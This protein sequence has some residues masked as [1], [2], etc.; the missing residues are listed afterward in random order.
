MKRIFFVVALFISASLSAQEK[1]LKVVWDVS[2]SDTATTAAVFRQVNNA[3]AL[4]PDMEIEVVFHGSAIYG[5]MKDST[6]FT[7]RIKTAKEKGVVL[8]ACNNSLRRLKIDTSKLVG[9]AIIVPSA[10]V[11]LIRKQSEGWSYLKSGH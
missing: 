3:L 4:V 5:L 6:I 8:A 7:S 1:K 2:D 10:V 11:E 9:E